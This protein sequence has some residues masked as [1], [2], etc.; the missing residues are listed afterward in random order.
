MRKEDC[1]QSGMQR[2]GATKISAQTQ[3]RTDDNKADLLL[4]QDVLI[5]TILNLPPDDVQLK[6]LDHSY[7]VPLCP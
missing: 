4:F 2:E 1:S 5:L 3:P 6:N 7:Q